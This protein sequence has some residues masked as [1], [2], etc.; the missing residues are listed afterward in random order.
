M[1]PTSLW[2]NILIDQRLECLRNA[3]SPYEYE[4]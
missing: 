3:E 1:D 4:L 2:G